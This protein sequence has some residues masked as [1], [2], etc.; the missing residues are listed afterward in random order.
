MRSRHCNPALVY[1]SKRGSASRK[2]WCSLRIKDH[3]RNAQYGLAAGTGQRLSLYSLSQ[4]YGPMTTEGTAKARPVRKCPACK[5]TQYEPRAGRCLRCGFD[6]VGKPC[7]K[8]VE[9]VPEVVGEFTDWRSLPSSWLPVLFVMQRFL[10]GLSQATIARRLGVARTY[11]AKIE[12]KVTPT[13]PHFHQVAEA[14]ETTP[15]HLMR[16]VEYLITGR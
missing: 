15:E 5:L 7:A 1:M 4:D 6:L 12:A 8:P 2:C 11:P 13:V 14:Y 3:N 10:R 16:M 9:I